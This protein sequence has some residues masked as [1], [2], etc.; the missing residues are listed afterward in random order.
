M[1]TRYRQ[2]YMESVA[3]GSPRYWVAA[4]PNVIATDIGETLVHSVLS[5]AGMWM[6]AGGVQYVAGGDS[7]T[8]DTVSCAAWGGIAAGLV[9]LAPIAGDVAADFL[10]DIRQGWERGA[11]HQVE[12]E[13]EQVAQ[14]AE[15]LSEDEAGAA[16]V[17]GEWWYPTNRNPG[18]LACYPTPR[19][20]NGKVQISDARMRAIFGAAMTGTSFSEREMT[21]K[22]SGLSGPR[23]RILQRDWRARTLYVLHEDGKGH[24]TSMGRRIAEIIANST[25]P[26]PG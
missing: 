17:E 20:R 18:H 9:M 21:E 3:A 15:L 4:P 24:F 23:F 1:G 25:P 11:G 5:F 16:R 19:D 2:L 22:V 7:G 14:A 13:P 6:L 8:I 26:A 10:S 12:P